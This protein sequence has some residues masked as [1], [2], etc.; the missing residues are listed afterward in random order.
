MAKELFETG[1]IVRDHSFPEKYELIR[2]GEYDD[3]IE[4]WARRSGRPTRP[5]HAM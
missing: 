1:K 2:H 5:N 4:D 3:L